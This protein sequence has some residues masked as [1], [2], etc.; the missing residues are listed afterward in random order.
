M[1][2]NDTRDNPTPYQEYPNP[3]AEEVQ[4]Y[5]TKGAPKTGMLRIEES[6]LQGIEQLVDNYS[7]SGTSLAQAEIT[8]HRLLYVTPVLTEAVHI[9]G[10][11]KVSITLSSS[12]PAANLSVWLVSLPWTEGR[13]SKMT[14]NIITRGWADPQNHHSIT[15]SEPLEAGQ[16]Y[17]VSFDLMPDDQIIPKGQKIGLMVFSSDKEFTLW[18]EPGTELKVDLDAT[19]LTLPIVGGIQ[20]YTNAIKVK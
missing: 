1:R 2:E 8:N 7:F 10:T 15:Q 19:T 17:E 14:D 4:L 13:R 16:F 11:A 5:L 12:K 20:S 3:E 18:P 9:S 6:K